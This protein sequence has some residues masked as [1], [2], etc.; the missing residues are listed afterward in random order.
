MRSREHEGARYRDC[1]PGKRNT[2]LA[3]GIDD[4]YRQCGGKE[5][6]QYGLP[7]RF[8]RVLVPMLLSI[9][10]CQGVRVV[11]QPCVNH[12]CATQALCLEEL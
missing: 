6:I 5:T 9:L 10:W 11:S 7:P 4:A 3:E 8:P 2:G 12:V 1:G